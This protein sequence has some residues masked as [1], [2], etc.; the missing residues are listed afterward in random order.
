M[1]WLR[2]NWPDLII[3]VAL[4]AVVALI[5]VTLLSGGSLASLVRRDTPPD[6]ALTETTPGGTTPS[7]T[8]GTPANN[9]DN[10]NTDA[11]ESSSNPDASTSGNSTAEG[12]NGSSTDSGVDVFVPGVP[13][14]QPDATS[15][16]AAIGSAGQTQVDGAADSAGT[17]Q[18]GA[19]Q[20][21]T[22]SGGAA[23]S[24]AAPADTGPL[25]EAAPDGGFRVAA[26][27]VDSRD[28]AAGLAESYRDAGYTVTVEQQNDLYLLWIGPYAARDGAER[29]ASRLIADDVVS[30]ALVYTYD[31]PDNSAEAGTAVA[32]ETNA[33]NNALSGNETAN[34]GSATSGA[35]SSQA[36]AGTSSTATAN[37]AANNN[38][39]NTG[40]NA[41]AN[42]D[43]NTS[44]GSNGASANATSATTATPATTAPT[45]PA[46]ATGQRYLQVGA[47]TS[48]E[49]AQPL[50]EQLVALDFNVT[51]NES[52]DG[53]V[54][55]FVGPFS[56]AQLPQTQQRL[57]A[58]GVTDAFPVIP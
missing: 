44:A 32:S 24:A 39:A 31:G 42:S 4:V 19:T 37:N 3:G 50:R 6:L 57:T 7:G 14:G 15:D 52:D 28:A 10:S 5:V 36:N 45:N 8:T 54:R 9:P 29:V 38:G 35:A 43:T 17:N 16:A 11:A 47:F 58:V 12:T 2:R 13:G 26:G 20:A 25:P 55:L 18:A 34:A 30:D 33:P 1:D 22:T 48:D 46:T 27:A 49:D 56:A 41:S 51:Q 53:L 21:G 23:Q 40:G